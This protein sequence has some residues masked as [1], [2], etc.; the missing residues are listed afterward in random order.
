MVLQIAFTKTESKIMKNPV[1][2]LQQKEK[3]KEKMFFLKYSQMICSN[4]II[5]PTYQNKQESLFLDATLKN[6]SLTK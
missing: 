3:K 2:R 5:Q 4:P 1:I 6:N